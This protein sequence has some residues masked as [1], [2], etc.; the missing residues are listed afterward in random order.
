MRDSLQV[1]IYQRIF[2]NWDV[3]IHADANVQRQLLS[4]LTMQATEN[5]VIDFRAYDFFFFLFLSFLFGALAEWATLLFYICRVIGIQPLLDML[6]DHF[7]FASK[8][9]STRKG[10]NASELALTLDEPRESRSRSSSISARDHQLSFHDVRELRAYVLFLFKQIV[11]AS[12]DTGLLMTIE[13][14]EMKRLLIY[15]NSIMKD[16][17]QLIDFVPLI[18]AILTEQ[19]SSV[20]DLFVGMGNFV[21]F[22]VVLSVAFHFCSPFYVT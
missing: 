8:P 2:F 22:L 14:E 7:W 9:N 19:P 16:A 10:S 3:W 4:D 17:D 5:A 11:S 12:K 1:Q 21:T 15:L 20:T 18:V 6:S 13:E